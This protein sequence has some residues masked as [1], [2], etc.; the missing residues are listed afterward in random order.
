MDRAEL[1]ALRAAIDAILV[2]P[3]AVRDQVAA[4]LAPNDVA[5]NA[6]QKPGNG[7]D[8]G[9]TSITAPRPTRPGKPRQAA[10]SGPLSNPEK[11]LLATLRDHPGVSAN[12]LA[13][14]AG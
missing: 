9:P 4:W 12:E 10:S 6:A 1:T 8:P 2:L 14:L 5:A 7:L 11:R 3:D 13:K